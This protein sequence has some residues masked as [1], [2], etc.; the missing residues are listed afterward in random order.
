MAGI[1]LVFLLTACNLTV[2]E[3]T[4]NGLIFYCNI[5]SSNH[6]LFFTSALA[7][8]QVL[9]NVLQIFVDWINLKLGISTC[10]YDGMTAYAKAWL[11]FVFPIYLWMIAGAIIFLSRRYTTIA[12]LMGRNAVKVLATLFLISYASLLQSIITAFSY[13]NLTYS[14]GSKKLVWYYDGNIGYLN[15]KHIVLFVAAIIVLILSVTYTV[16]L[17]SVQCSRKFNSRI[18][19]WVP[20]FKPF[21][22]AYT[23]PYKDSYQFWTGHLLMIRI[24][25]LLAYTINTHDHPS[26]N[27]LLIISACAH[28]LLLNVWFV[29]GVYKKWPLDVLE[30]SSFLNLGILSA[31]TVYV[32]KSEGNQMAVTYASL[33]V[34]LVIFIGVLLY[35]T[36]RLMANTRAWRILSTWLLQRLRT[37]TERVMEPVITARETEH[38]LLPPENAR[39]IQHREPL[40]AS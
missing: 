24:I 40:H 15:E 28:L 20:R 2:T 32:L 39:F 21:F 1:V 8:S 14:D 25:I 27:L 17:A 5:V 9:S 23:G 4:I 36:Y 6:S 12:R 31:A 29:R 18:C 22:D 34:A 16:I 33:S 19:S 3:G 11:Q 26:V 10:F 7:E 30:S 37:T 38:L 35:H 13:T